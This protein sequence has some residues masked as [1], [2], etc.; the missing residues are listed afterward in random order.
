MKHSIAIIGNGNVGQALAEGWRAAGHEVVFGVREPGADPAEQSVSS[1]AARSDIVVL[2]TPWTALPDVLK[3]CG[4]LSRKIII[5]CTNPVN[6]TFDGLTLGVDDSGGETV[7]RLAPEARVV[8]AFNTVGFNIMTNPMFGGVAASML[9][10]GDDSDA[11][12]VV[13]QLSADLGFDPVDAGPLT[14]S[15]GLE[16]L[17]WLWISMAMKFG[18]G[19]EIAF[20]LHR[21]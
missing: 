2:A 19:R 10:A 8:K 6:A 13:A 15:R 7:A 12:A 14:Q 21:R 4:D 5:D 11:K 18:H 3:A 17:A 20:V 9:I 1:A 16:A